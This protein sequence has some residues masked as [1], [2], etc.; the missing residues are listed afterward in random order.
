MNST[1][2]IVLLLCLLVGGRAGAAELNL[3]PT[4]VTL[5]GPHASQRLILVSEDGGKVVA[6]RGPDAKF[7]S[8]QPA[9]ATVD[10]RG[11]VRP[12][13]DGEAVI[14][15]T[16]GDRQATAKVKVTKAKEAAPFGFTNDVIP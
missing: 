14:T 13:A 11:V 7:T 1:C 4:D 2:R 9:V 16:H 3:L 12:V 15:A 10:D 6:D 5:T 8:S